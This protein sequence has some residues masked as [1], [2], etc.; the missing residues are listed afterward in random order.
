MTGVNLTLEHGLKIRGALNQQG[1]LKISLNAT[2]CRTRDCTE[3]NIS[4]FTC[5]SIF[6]ENFTKIFQ[7][8]VK[9]RMPNTLRVWLKL[10]LLAV[11]L[12]GFA[13]HT[14]QSQAAKNPLENFFKVSDRSQTC[15]NGWGGVSEPDFHKS[16]ISKIPGD[17]LGIELYSMTP[18]IMIWI[19]CKSQSDEATNFVTATDCRYKKTLEYVEAAQDIPF[20]V[21]S[22][23]PVQKSYV[24]NAIFADPIQPPAKKYVHKMTA[25]PGYEKYYS[26]FQACDPNNAI[27]QSVG[28]YGSPAKTRKIVEDL[29]TID[30]IERIKNDTNDIIAQEAL[31]DGGFNFK[32]DLTQSSSSDLEDLAYFKR[33][34]NLKKSEKLSKLC[35]EIK[36]SQN[37]PLKVSPL[38]KESCE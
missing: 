25:W 34:T 26:D 28:N 16:R 4:Y 18:E 17:N 36:Y 12:T 2:R 24:I 9:S 8:I 5:Q 22:N 30:L 31:K 38:T 33:P 19:F 11:L 1:F 32:S 10:T 23:I 37:Q 13:S 35:F 27:L 15:I 14:G 21:A 7:T 29:I 20:G 3:L 6:S